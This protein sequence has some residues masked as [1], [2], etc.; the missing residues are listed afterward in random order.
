MTQAA[1]LILTHGTTDLQILLRDELGRLWRAAPDKAIVRRFHEWLLN[2]QRD[3]ARIVSLPDGLCERKSEATITDWSG[4]KFALWVAD[5]AQDAMPERSADGYLQLV[6]PKIGPVLEAWCR[7]RASAEPTGSRVVALASKLEAASKKIGI[8]LFLQ[9]VL[10][11]STDRGTDSQEPIATFTFLRDWLKFEGLSDTSIHEAVFLHSGEQLESADSPIAPAIAERIERVVRTFYDRTSRP[12]LLLAT[13]GGLPQIKPLLAELAVLL[14]DNKAQNLFKTELGVAGLLL[15]TPVDTLRVRRQCLEQVRRGAILD[16]FSMAAPYHD[17]PDARLWVS[18]LQQSAALINGN[19]VGQKAK[20]HELQHI[21]DCAEHA[22]CLLVA[23]RVE[24]AL[25]TGRWLDAI[26]G[27]LTFLEAALHDAITSWA[28]DALHSYQPR[29]RYMQ[30]K[31]PPHRL[32]LQAGAVNP[33]EGK[34]ATP[35]SYQM[36]TIGEKAL[37]AWDEVLDNAAIHRLRETIHSHN[38]QGDARPR[39]AEYRNYNTHGVM[40]QQEINEA[41]CRFMGTNLWSQS[42]DTPANRPS[43][44]KCFLARPLVTDVIVSLTGQTVKPL[45][46]YQNLLKQLEAQLL[47]PSPSIA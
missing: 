25:L 3:I 21:L 31:K 11:L 43:P 30:F 40:T 23:I 32:L 24:T 35:L 2:E 28:K 29:R 38:P 34:D 1:Q 13:M 19:P 26:N 20:L 8:D 45:A 15:R 33:W 22:A 10:V 41:V 42:V 17:D 46:L 37:G 5:E 27:T 4:D 36:N 18:A 6:L 39:L 16:A 14:A 12:K 44:G 9:S 47:D 7:Q